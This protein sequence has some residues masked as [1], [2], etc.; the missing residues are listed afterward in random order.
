MI[1]R[2][3]KT[4]TNGESYTDDELEDEMLAR[5][6][7][8]NLL[9]VSYKRLKTFDVKNGKR[10]FIIS[11]NTKAAKSIEEDPYFFVGVEPM[12][13][14]PKID[15]VPVH[16]TV[17]NVHILSKLVLSPALTSCCATHLTTQ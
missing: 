15:L 10:V 2:L 5:R 3:P 17:Y 13:A 16:C 4:K 14:Q 12:K 9:R 6:P 8:T 11:V 1:T 7:D